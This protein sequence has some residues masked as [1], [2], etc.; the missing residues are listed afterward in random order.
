[1]E[2][3]IVV[4][5]AASAAGASALRWALAEAAVRRLPLTAVRAWMPTA[6][7]AYYPVGI[8]MPEAM[9]GALEA[10]ALVDEQLALAREAVPGAGGISSQAVAIM[11]ATAQVLVDAGRQ[12][13]LV[14]V[15]TRGAGALSRT[16]LGSVSSAVLHH[17]TGPV[18]VI[19][20]L[21]AQAGPPARVLVGVDHSEQSQAAVRF[22]VDHARRHGATLVPVFVQ[23]RVW[24][25]GSPGTHREQDV[26]VRQEV[27]QELLLDAVGATAAGLT[28][29][30][31][32]V[33]GQAAA[34]LTAMVNQQDVLV[35]GSR[36]RGGFASL[37]LGSTSTQ[38]A[39]HASCPVI[40]IR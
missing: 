28:V 15:G 24:A 11:G 1:M 18:A 9:D 40:V 34:A 25:A 27:E 32:V 6:F 13:A 21:P 22:A 33:S 4:G 39:Q 3:G 35:V 7:G 30:P 20:E 37:L 36:G 5:V 12:A 38:C 26:V 8:V 31:T 10:Q 29:R 19:P 2:P 14:V 17:G 23:E 16:V